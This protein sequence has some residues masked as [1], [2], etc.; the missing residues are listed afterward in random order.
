MA[1]G[2]TANENGNTREDGIEEEGPNGAYAH[3]IE[4]RA[5]PRPNRS[6]ALEDSICAMFLLWFCLA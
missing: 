4:Q 3:E 1:K 6:E 5:F 2:E